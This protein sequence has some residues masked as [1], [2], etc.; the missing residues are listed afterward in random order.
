MLK[1]G[2]QYAGESLYWEF[3]LSLVRALNILAIANASLE[4]VIYITYTGN[5]TLFMLL[6]GEAS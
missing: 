2:Y 4:C 6:E 3:R 5:E 1:E